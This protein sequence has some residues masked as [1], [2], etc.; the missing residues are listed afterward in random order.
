MG[1]KTEA[2]LL[3]EHHLTELGLTPFEAEYRFH[4]T[5]K[6]RFDYAVPRVKLAIEI[7]GGAFVQGRHTRGAAFEAD[8]VKYAQGAIL[9]WTIMRFT[10]GMI[11]RG[12]SKALLEVYSER[13]VKGAA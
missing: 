6:W 1:K 7:E 2:A 13:Y 10:P 9:G 11:R 8:C 3:I 4:P 5:R 12:E